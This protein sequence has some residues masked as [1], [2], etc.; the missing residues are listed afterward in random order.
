VR[1]PPGL[2]L[3]RNVKFLTAKTS[4]VQKRVEI[5]LSVDRTALGLQ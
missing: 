3:P 4:V 2:A 5:G 1:G